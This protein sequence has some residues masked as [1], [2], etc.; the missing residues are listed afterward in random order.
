MGDLEDI[1]TDFSFHD[2]IV[3]KIYFTANHK[4]IVIDIN[5][6]NRDF[7]DTFLNCCIEYENIIFKKGY[8]EIAKIDW[9]K[10]YGSVLNYELDNEDIHYFIEITNIVEKSTDYIK[11]IFMA[12]SYKIKVNRI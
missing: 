2:S 9:N 10:S 6:P 1:L 12:S 3:N 4:N 11:L 8:V 7:S 5:L